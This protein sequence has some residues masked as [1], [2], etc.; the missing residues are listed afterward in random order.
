MKTLIKYSSILLLLVFFVS[1]SEDDSNEM[2]VEVSITDAILSLVNEHRESK[3]LEKLVRNSTADNLAIEHSK[4]MIS[5]NKI[6][7]DNFKNRTDNL[8]QMEK[9]QGI[10]ENVA[11]GYHTANEVVTAWLKSSIHKENI[12]GNFTHTGIAAVKNAK[13]TYYFT[14]L[15]YR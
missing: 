1:C 3:G 2:I 12:E 14:Q 7:H 15:F 9:A 5:E 8:K 11:Y 10:G 13:G 4:Y 6:S